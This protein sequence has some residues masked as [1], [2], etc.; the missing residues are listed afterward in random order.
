MIQV[1]SYGV[2][3]A[4]IQRPLN[5]DRILVAPE[6]GAFG[7]F[8][9]IGGQR[10]GEVA[11]ELAMATVH[12]Y[13][14]SSTNPLDVTWPYGYNFNLSLG[15]NRVLTAV[16]LANRRVW[17][18]AEESL[19]CAGMGTT[20]AVALITDNA[21]TIANVGDS[22]IYRFRDGE[23]TQLSID[24]T[25][26]GA[27]AKQNIVSA[28]VLRKHPLRNMLTQAAGQKEELDVHLVEE[29]L[30]PGDVLLL[31]SD[32]LHGVI[33]D[34]AIASHI[35]AGTSAEAITQSLLKAALEAGAPD[36]VSVITLR[37]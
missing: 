22:R 26:A 8:D 21:A 27:M 24:D 30:H 18:K 34:S 17:R 4:G 14:E 11:A 20:V 5:E 25:M 32:G 19:E 9:G 29:D 15:G 1:E 37:F 33:E 23:L 12:R 2:T 16:R 13:I 3:D 35:T 28:E 7:V 36:N 6:L 31:T 10:R